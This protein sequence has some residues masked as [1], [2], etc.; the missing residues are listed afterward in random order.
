MVIRYEVENDN[1]PYVDTVLDL[2]LALEYQNIA[3][4]KTYPFIPIYFDVK[5]R[6]Q[7]S[8]VS[9]LCLEIIS[10]DAY[11]TYNVV[12]KE[13]LMD[14]AKLGYFDKYIPNDKELLQRIVD[15]G[16]TVEFGEHFINQPFDKVW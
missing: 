1:I 14:K 7:R 3:K 15:L 11:L 5:Q 12:D 6:V 2:T 8:F 10:R 16:Y 13:D 9:N 4:V